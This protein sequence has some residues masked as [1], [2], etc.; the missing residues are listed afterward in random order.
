MVM[1]IHQIVLWK[2]N[3]I[4][5][6]ENYGSQRSS[7]PF[8]AGCKFIT[9]IPQSSSLTHSSRKEAISSLQEEGMKNKYTEDW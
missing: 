9:V 2:T 7:C 4:L 8:N 6:W 1:F 5:S 3:K